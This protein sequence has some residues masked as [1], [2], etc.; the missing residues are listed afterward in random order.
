MHKDIKHKLNQDETSVD[1]VVGRQ[2]SDK[3]NTADWIWYIDNKKILIFAN[4]SFKNSVFLFSGYEAKIGKS[5]FNEGMDKTLLAEWDTL[6]DQAL[7][8]ASI[9]IDHNIYIRGNF[10]S[11]EIS[12]HPILNGSLVSGV[13]CYSRNPKNTTRHKKGIT[14]TEEKYKLLFKENPTP[15][16]IYDFQT[17]EILK[18]NNSAIEKYGYSY[19]ELITMTIL[20]FKPEED[21]PDFLLWKKE[22]GENLKNIGTF[23][24]KKKDNEIFLVETTAH[25]IQFN[26][27]K[28][29]LSVMN[30]ISE[31]MAAE[32]LIEETSTVLQ[33][34]DDRFKTVFE[35]SLDG[36]SITDQDGFIRE[37]NPAICK[38]LGYTRA[39]LVNMHRDD[40]LIIEKNELDNI[41]NTRKTKGNYHGIHKFKHKNGTTIDMEVSTT[42]FEDHTSIKMTYTSMKDIT[43]KLEASKKLEQSEQLYK[44]LFEKN[45]DAIFS[46]D[47]GG[48]F[49]SI[50]DA[51]AALIE[52][53]KEELLEKTYIPFLS[54]D[55]LTLVMDMFYM[56]REGEKISSDVQ[57]ITLKAKI[58]LINL[59]MLP[60]I[61]NK[62]IVGVY[63]IM[64]DVTA[65]KNVKDELKEKEI[66]FQSLIENSYDM[67]T[68]FNAEGEIEYVSPSV[69]KYFGYNSEEPIQKNIL[70]IIHPDDLTLAQNQLNTVLNN[71]G[72]PVHTRL[73]NKFKEDVY[74][75]V[76]GTVTN[77][78]EVSG[79][80]AIVANFKDITNQY[81]VEED[82][83]VSLCQVQSAAERQ[84]AILNSLGAHIALL[85]HEGVI[86]EVNDAWRKFAD[87]NFL[88]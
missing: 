65:L 68:L 46:L 6:Y 35:S 29:V 57:M 3:D 84:S 38:L 44:S 16:V 63:G 23:R 87:D 81:N 73:R 71:P 14:I 76:E 20:D 60:I 18:A 75:W 52:C 64:K 45:P 34:S 61:V 25:I 32:R 24:H 9:T 85:D 67:V 7:K 4:E 10:I 62:D 28:S 5:V 55:N 37:V 59:T 49:I 39:E 31:K 47:M 79:V 86:I 53:T 54:D 42:E 74:M 15:M 51:L 17:L 88:I 69:R 58:R 2:D 80:H 56:A 33:F 72:V 66:R 82:L 77:M 26:G 21:L 78:L 70:N 8:G 19:D 27:K 22:L 43:E 48:K 12:F 36:L 1:R 83:K 41:I 40:I 30:D 50:N 13:A 11:T